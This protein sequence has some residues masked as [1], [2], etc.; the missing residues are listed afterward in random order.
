MSN[1]QRTRDRKRKF[2]LMK[3]GS[4]E[5]FHDFFNEGVINLSI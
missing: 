4:V 1:L 3:N 2:I 5:L